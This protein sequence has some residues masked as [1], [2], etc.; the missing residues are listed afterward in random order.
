MNQKI[1]LITGGSRGL[2]RNAA[3]KLAE[4]GVDIILTYRSQESEAQAVVAEIEMAVQI[5]PWSPAQV[6]EVAGLLDRHYVA[7]VAED[8][9]GKVQAYLIAQVLCEIGR[10]SCRERVSS[11]V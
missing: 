1:A 7:W 10:A 5:E 8:G 9:S 2:G 11:P 6:L 3:L 4:H